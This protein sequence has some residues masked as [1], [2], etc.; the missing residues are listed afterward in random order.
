MLFQ[1]FGFPGL[2]IHGNSVDFSGED[3]IDRIPF[4]EADR[5]PNTGFFDGRGPQKDDQG[6]GFSQYRGN[7]HGPSHLPGGI[8][9]LLPG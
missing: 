1:K 5:T 6:F 8:D 3:V 7:I 9:R 2:P 4:K